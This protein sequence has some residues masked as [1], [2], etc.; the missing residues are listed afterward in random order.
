MEVDD[1]SLNIVSE[2]QAQ[3]GKSLFP[4]NFI[5]IIKTWN[6]NCHAGGLEIISHE[7]FNP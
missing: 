4:I 1:I 3:V 2:S 6:F 7:I 5:K